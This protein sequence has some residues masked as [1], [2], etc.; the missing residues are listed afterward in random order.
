M[1]AILA[2]QHGR[3]RFDTPFAPPD[4]VADWRKIGLLWTWRL[5]N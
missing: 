1:I 5:R 3:L 2:A 4:D